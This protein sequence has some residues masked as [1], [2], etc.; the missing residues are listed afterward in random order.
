MDIDGETHFLQDRLHIVVE[1]ANSDTVGS[2]TSFKVKAFFTCI[3]AE[4]E[5]HV[6][7]VLYALFANNDYNPVTYGAAVEDM[8]SETLEGWI[9]L[10]VRSGRIECASFR[11]VVMLHRITFVG[12]I[13]ETT[14]GGM[15]PVLLLNYKGGCVCN[16]S[17]FFAHLSDS[18]D[19][20]KYRRCL[21]IWC[22]W[23]NK[24]RP[25]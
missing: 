23:Q 9:G 5:V 12:H 16:S 8:F 1:V 4:F 6:S 25:C 13:V 17:P 18:F 7:L 22:L 2:D 15:W 24:M 21:N 10:R 19:F 20:Y 14:R 11:A 3:T